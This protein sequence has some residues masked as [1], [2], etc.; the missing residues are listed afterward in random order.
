[1]SHKIF[2]SL[3]LI[4]IVIFMKNV[5]SDFKHHYLFTYF[6]IN[7]LPLC[8]ENGFRHR[9]RVKFSE[10]ITALIKLLSMPDVD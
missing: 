10:E 3:D 6:D 5:I 7:V 2:Q 8:S 1:M 4:H 9:F